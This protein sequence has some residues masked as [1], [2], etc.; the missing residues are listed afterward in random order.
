LEVIHL[1]HRLGS[2]QLIK[3]PSLLVKSPSVMP[4]S[5]FDSDINAPLIFVAEKITMVFAAES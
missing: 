4:Q 1:N 5:P 2:F 3:S